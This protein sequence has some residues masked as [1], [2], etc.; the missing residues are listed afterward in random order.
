M[1]ACTHFYSICIDLYSMQLDGMRLGSQFKPTNSASA[2][3]IFGVY[4]TANLRNQIF[5]GIPNP[6][7]ESGESLK[8]IE[9]P[10]NL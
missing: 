4:V 8:F 9:I 3:V 10:R 6:F 2:S 7:R 5:P 1:M